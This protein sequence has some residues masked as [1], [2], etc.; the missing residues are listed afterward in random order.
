MTGSS[1]FRPRSAGRV[2]IPR[3]GLPGEPV[4]GARLAAP[5]DEVAHLRGELERLRSELDQ[6]LRAMAAREVIEQA[7]GLLMG[8]FRCPDE[9]AFGMLRELSQR[10]NTKLRAVAVEIV[11]LARREGRVH[12]PGLD[13]VAE[14]VL[15]EPTGPARGAQPGGG[16]PSG[17]R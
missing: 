4:I 1:A 9:Q 6:A 16:R 10:A 11:D 12:F 14:A 15:G 7:K 3:S 8:Y 5:D 17:W 2:D 13:A